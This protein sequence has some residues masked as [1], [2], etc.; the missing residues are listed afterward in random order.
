MDRVDEKYLEIF[1]KLKSEYDEYD[2]L[3]S[4]VEIMTDNKL[5]SHYLKKKKEIQ[6][7][8]LLCKKY[9]ALE[10]DKITNNEIYDLETDAAV[11]E[12]IV[13]ENKKLS[14]EQELTFAKM[15]EVYGKM[16]S[17]EEQKAKIEISTKSVGSEFVP[18]M[19]DMFFEFAK[20][21]GYLT[22]EE[23]LNGEISCVIEISG[24]SAYDKLKFFTGLYK[25]VEFGNVAFGIVSVFDE[26]IFSDEIKEEDVVI[27]TSKSSGAGGQHINK[28]ESAVRLIHKPTGISVECQDERSQLKN[29]LRAFENLKNKILQKNK[30]IQEKYVQNQRKN[31]KNAIF[32]D[33]PA[34]II[35]F[36]TKKVSVT[37]TK[38]EYKLSDVVQGNLT[39]IINDFRV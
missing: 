28:T 1:N 6:E 34:F 35:D 39:N 2:E 11:K 38:K 3:L 25:I 15:K 37:K 32:S 23:K 26:K 30:E 36:D 16:F 12:N 20:E 13:E 29:K 17:G 31:T 10:N 19:K 33:T 24:E 4:S 9:N 7:V 5:F 22:N 27:Q 18:K 8:A 21:Q 14:A